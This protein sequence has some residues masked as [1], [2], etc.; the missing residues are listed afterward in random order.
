[1]HQSSDHLAILDGLGIMHEFSDHLAIL[2]KSSC[3][4]FMELAFSI[5]INKDVSSANKQ[6]F[7]SMLFTMSRKG[8]VLVQSLVAFQHK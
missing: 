6:I 3:K 5:T 2:N 1:M 4:A 7:V 8:R